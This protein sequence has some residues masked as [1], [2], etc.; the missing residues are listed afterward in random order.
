MNRLRLELKP[1]C[2]CNILVKAYLRFPL[3]FDSSSCLPLTFATEIKA[4]LRNQ[5]AASI[6]LRR[7]MPA[8]RLAVPPENALILKVKFPAALCRTCDFS[9]IFDFPLQAASWHENDRVLAYV[10][11]HF[12]ALH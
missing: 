5:Y 8:K 12:Y 9:K 7:L 6:T 2:H 10:H 11:F 1:E 4:I 3:H